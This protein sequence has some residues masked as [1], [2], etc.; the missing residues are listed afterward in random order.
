MD[1]IKE[2]DGYIEELF[3]DIEA[4]GRY[5]EE[6]AGD[7]EEALGWTC[8]LESDGYDMTSKEQDKYMALIMLKSRVHDF[9]REILNE[10]HEITEG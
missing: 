10:L 1:L 7:K 5:D 3:E 2:I 6:A 9:N 8:M 4:D